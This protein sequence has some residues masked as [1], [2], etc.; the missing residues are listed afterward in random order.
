MDYHLSAEGNDKEAGDA[1]ARAWRTLARANRRKFQPG[2]RLRLRGGDVFDGALLFNPANAAS[3]IR[4]P[5][6]IA[7]YGDGKAT[8]KAIDADAIL[9]Q[10]LGGFILRDLKLIGP[11]RTPAKKCG[12]H[13]LNTLRG[14]VKLPFVRIENVE[15]SGFGMSGIQV[16][17]LPADNSKSGYRDVRLTR[18]IVRENVYHGIHFYG[19]WDTKATTYAHAEVVISHCVAHGNTGDPDYRENHSGNGILLGD[20]DDGRIEYCT[21]YNNGFLCN[22]PGG[23]P[24]GIWTHASNRI[25]IQYCASYNNRTGRSTDGGGFDFDGGVT[26][27]ILQYNYSANNDGAGY[28]LYVYNGAP[29]T[30]RG[31]IV[32]CNISENDGRKNRFGMIHIANDGS[33]VRDIEVYHNTIITS[34]TP[35]GTPFALLASDAQNIRLWNNLFLTQGGIPLL[36]LGAKLPG[37][38]AMGNAYW[39]GDAP[40]LL[41]DNGKEYRSL[42]DWRK[43]SGQETYNGNDAGMQVDPHLTALRPSAQPRDAAQLSR[44]AAFRLQPNSP[45]IDAALDLKTRFGVDP[46][47]RDFWGNKR[48]RGKAADIGAHEAK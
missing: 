8:I 44:L 32:R 26:N 4:R 37:F 33:G 22:N 45:L 27:S 24:V 38:Q 34:P 16:G 46:G 6:T 29:Y 12:V 18:C 48:P 1:P 21:A 31:N 19:A 42:A 39:S 43:A 30:F 17:A 10:D 15:A 11:G 41:R 47:A 2:D 13:F 3:D 14:G 5:I 7:S 40:F 36:E 35:T 9:V 23:G 28:L 25:V 20:T